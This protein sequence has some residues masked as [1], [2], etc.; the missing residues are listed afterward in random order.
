MEYRKIQKGRSSFIEGQVLNSNH[1]GV[2]YCSFH[3]LRSDEGGAVTGRFSSSNPNLQQVPSRDKILAPLIRGMFLPHYGQWRSKDYAS[4]EFRLM[5]HAASGSGAALLRQQYIDDPST[6]YHKYVQAL[7]ED[8]IC[9]RIERK[10][11]KNLNFGL[12]FGM[13]K[14]KLMRS[15]ELPEEQATELIQVYHTAL[16]YIRTT[17]NKASDVAQHRGYIKT[18]L[19]RRRRFTEWESKD[20]NLRYQLGT[21]SNQEQATEAC[22]GFR[23]VLNDNK[24]NIIRLFGDEALE[25]YGLKC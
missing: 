2:V 16:P 12:I 10:P 18:I 5:A 17:F 24:R 15:L 8:L 1:N 9:R 6:D 11:L 14:P 23:G 22:E 21:F 4:I 7:V 19:G 3:P 13:G 25:I 20:Y